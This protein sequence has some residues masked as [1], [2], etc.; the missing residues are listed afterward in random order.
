MINNMET[1]KEIFWRYTD[2]KTQI[3]LVR[4]ANEKY[5]TILI[6]GVKIIISDYVI[7]ELTKAWVKK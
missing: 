4:F 7:N 1:K 3:D 2:E 5:A 6:S